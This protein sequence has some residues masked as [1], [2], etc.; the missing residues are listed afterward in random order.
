MP[1]TRNPQRLLCL[2]CRNVAEVPRDKPI[3][4]CP[5][6]GANSVPADLDDTI[7]LTI[8]SQELRILTFWAERWASHIKDFP[9]CEAAP[10]VIG[11]IVNEIGKATAAPL[12]L[13]QEVADLRAEVGDVKVVREDGTEIDM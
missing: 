11:G 2:R 12:T 5:N 9:N 4:R 3:A 8:T 10:T 7:T 6:C 13:S 1:E